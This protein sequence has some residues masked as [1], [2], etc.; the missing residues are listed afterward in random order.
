MVREIIFQFREFEA[1][2]TS[3]RRFAKR[4]RR[5]VITLVLEAASSTH[6]HQNPSEKMASNSAP[7]G[8]NLRNGGSAAYRCHNKRLAHTQPMS[9]A[10]AV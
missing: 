4:I 1:F 5:S 7:D 6:D 2:P 8:Q 9:G 3:A 10:V